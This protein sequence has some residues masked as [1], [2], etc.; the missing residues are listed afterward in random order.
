MDRNT[1]SEIGSFKIPAS[2]LDD[3]TREN[4]CVDAFK[5]SSRVRKQDIP[6]NRHL[7]H[8]QKFRLETGEYGINVAFRILYDFFIGNF[9]R[10]YRHF[11][12]HKVC[13]LF[14][15]SQKKSFRA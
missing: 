12:F 11:G 2:T 1:T 14:P 7:W 3:S 4:P 10:E 8:D 5:A 6:R 9:K 13:S 15:H